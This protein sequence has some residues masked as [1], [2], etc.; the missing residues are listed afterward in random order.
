M[1][2]NF[3]TA[4]YGQKK[5]PSRQKAET[6]SPLCNRAEPKRV[7]FHALGTDSTFRYCILNLHNLEK[8]FDFRLFRSPFCR[9]FLNR[10]MRPICHDIRMR[11]PLSRTASGIFSPMPPLNCSRR[12]RS[13]GKARTGSSDFQNWQRANAP[14][15]KNGKD[16]RYTALSKVISGLLS[17]QAGGEIARGHRPYPVSNPGK[18]Q[19]GKGRLIRPGK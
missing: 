1:T 13:A 9:L 10:R 16:A 18:L 6:G 4:L 12:S 14:C 11:L 15:G 17:A 8:G 2:K 7:K 3:K 5:S 19:I